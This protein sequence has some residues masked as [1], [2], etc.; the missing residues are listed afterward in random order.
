[1]NYYLNNHDIFL[2]FKEEIKT[3]L[4]YFSN[5]NYKF[6]EKEINESSYEDFVAIDGGNNSFKDDLLNFLGCNYVSVVA[7]SDEGL[8]EKR[9]FII[10][11][12]APLEIK[13]EILKKLNLGFGEADEIIK[14][15]EEKDYHFEKN[16]ENSFT[17][18]IRNLLEL[19]LLAKYSKEH[20][21]TRDG[22]FFLP[23]LI[24]LK[25][26]I[27]KTI[28]KENVFA[29][30]KS[31]KI[32][33][34]K[35]LLMNLKENSIFEVDERL[36][37]EFYNVE[38]L[39]DFKTYIYSYFKSFYQ[40]ETNEEKLNL[41]INSLKKQIKKGKHGYPKNLIMADKLAKASN[42]K[43]KNLERKLLALVYQEEELKSIVEIIKEKIFQIRQF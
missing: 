11:E 6:K 15:L 24:N 34:N 43:I 9:E 20:F 36:L 28:N 18:K 33:R 40:L 29:L 14:K 31:S 2:D 41:V 16:E 25:K 27:N 7:Y 10:F 4:K 3:I 22:S 26:E 30:A 21:A 37:K 12:K 8:L 35:V 17:L 42:V 23:D 13:K 1:M 19:E 5:F 32:L 38:N 39:L